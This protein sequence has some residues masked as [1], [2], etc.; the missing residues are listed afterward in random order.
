MHDREMTAA[1][2]RID[3]RRDFFINE[4]DTCARNVCDA[5]GRCSDRFGCSPVSDDTWLC[6]PQDRNRLG[7]ECDFQ[8]GCGGGQL[9]APIGPQRA[10]VCAAICRP[11]DA[12]ACGPATC[13]DFGIDFGVCPLGSSSIGE[14]CDSEGQC[15]GGHCVWSLDGS[16]CSIGCD[17]DDECP[18]NWSCRVY[19]NDRQACFIHSAPN[20]PHGLGGQG[21]GGSGGGSMGGAGGMAGDPGFPVVPDPP[22]MEERTDMGLPASQQPPRTGNPTAMVPAPTRRPCRSF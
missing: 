12:N 22:N 21:E 19:G 5:F 20:D 14:F 11:G 1:P 8:N 9:C 17:N 15:L 6:L 3:V 16:I 13:I 10:D 2:S 4:G 7:T 18:E